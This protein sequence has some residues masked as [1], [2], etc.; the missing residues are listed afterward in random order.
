MHTCQ[1]LLATLAGCCTRATAADAVTLHPCVVWRCVSMI[2]HFDAAGG[3]IA[4]PLMHV[5]GTWLDAGFA[6]HVA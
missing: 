2:H 5:S 4:C 3:G 1:L 6:G